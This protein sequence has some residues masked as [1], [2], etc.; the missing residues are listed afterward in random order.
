MSWLWGA[1]LLPL[2]ICGAMCM[3][4]MVLAAVG[5]GRASRDHSERR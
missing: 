3:G 5:I 1:A 2:L 4:G